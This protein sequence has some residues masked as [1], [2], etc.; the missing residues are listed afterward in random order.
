MAS[1][2]DEIDAAN[3]EPVPADLI[4]LALTSGTFRFDDGAIEVFKAEGTTT[5]TERGRPSEGTW[6]IE[7]Q[8]FCSFWP[9]NFT[10]CYEVSWV[11][12]SE[13]ITGLLFTDQASPAQFVG[14][15]ST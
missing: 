14:R 4:P 7:R 10:G 9:P 13:R 12:E 8:H 15:Y 6:Y 3:G 1:K 11:V 2:L 5:Y